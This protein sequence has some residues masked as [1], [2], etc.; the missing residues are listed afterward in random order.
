MGYTGCTKPVATVDAIIC[1]FWALYI[2]ALFFM[3]HITI[4][5]KSI[6]HLIQ[7]KCMNSM[8]EAVLENLGRINEERKKQSHVWRHAV[9][10][11]KKSAL[12]LVMVK[13]LQNL[14]PGFSKKSYG[15]RSVAAAWTNPSPLSFYKYYFTI[16]PYNYIQ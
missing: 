6:Q 16:L 14:C 15:Q 2:I 10:P 5:Q 9:Q 4:L 12:Q 13:N 7:Q 8:H 1:S 3:E 11:Y